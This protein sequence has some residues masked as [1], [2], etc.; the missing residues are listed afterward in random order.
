MLN[1]E[2]LRQEGRTCHSPSTAAKTTIKIFPSTAAREGSGPSSQHL[3]IA[4]LAISPRFPHKV[5]NASLHLLSCLQRELPLA[6][7]LAPPHINPSPLRQGASRNLCKFKLSQDG[8]LGRRGTGFVSTKVSPVPS[9]TK[10][11]KVLGFLQ[12]WC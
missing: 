3:C 11:P 4:N 12:K 10:K 6:A 8:R 5:F 7:L 9:C 1:T 2:H